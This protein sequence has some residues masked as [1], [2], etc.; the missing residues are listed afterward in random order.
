MYKL[1]KNECFEL[2]DLDHNDIDWKPLFE[3]Q[4]D[5]LIR[6]LQKDVSEGNGDD[7]FQETVSSRLTKAEKLD[8]LKTAKKKYST[9][10]TVYFDYE[11]QHVENILKLYHAT[12]C[13]LKILILAK[14][15]N[16]SKIP[17]ELKK[18]VQIFETQIQKNQYLISSARFTNGFILSN[19]E[20]L[21]GITRI[22]F[23]PLRERFELEKCILSN[24][25]YHVKF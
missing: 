23:A 15:F 11:D 1:I 6:Q 2:V 3:N 10:F 20:Y 14:K 16:Y 18:F 21:F 19:D 4:T 9:T 22:N 25:V 8:L 24:Q 13:N 17:P 7:I 5:K 12:S